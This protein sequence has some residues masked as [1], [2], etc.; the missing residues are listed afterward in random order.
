MCAMAAAS[1]PAQASSVIPTVESEV[2]LTSRLVK[3][4]CPKVAKAALEAARF[5]RTEELARFSRLDAKV[6]AV[7]GSAGIAVALIG[8]LAAKADRAGAQWALSI[9]GLLGLIASGLALQALRAR[10][11]DAGFSAERIFHRDLIA[12]GDKDAESRYLGYQAADHWFAS[13]AF[14]ASALS[15]S[16]WLGAATWAFLGAIA[17]TAIGSVLFVMHC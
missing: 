1:I 9:A 14:T 2:E 11:I 6:T 4:P 16:R 15:K 12:D 13:Q 3:M 7:L 5:A 8:N 10:P 17:V